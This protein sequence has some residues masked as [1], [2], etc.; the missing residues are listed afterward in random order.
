MSLVHLVAL[1]VMALAPAERLSAP[2][3]TPLQE[4]D[5]VMQCQTWWHD[6]D[7]NGGAA[8]AVVA[9]NGLCIN[10]FI[11]KGRDAVILE[12]LGKTS[13][14]VP[15]VV[16]IRSGGGD[17]DASMNVAEALQRRRP[18]V[19]ADMVCASSCSD[20]IITAGVR[21]IVRADTFLV[22]HGGIT[23]RLLDDAGP[24]IEALAKAD[25]K[26]KYD[27]AMA[28]MRDVIGA[29][30]ARQDSFMVRA[31]VD[32]KIFAWMDEANSKSGE[33]I[34][35]RCPADSH[36]IQYSREALARFGLTFDEYGAPRS[37]AEVDA[38]LHKLG[39]QS[40]ICYWQE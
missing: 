19:I 38:L 40:K 6:M 30:M 25:P 33:A 37:Q 36:I 31:G 20:Y 34:A 29:Q 26:I 27:A 24:Q 28:H 15:L 17:F 2:V 1:M 22:Y 35:S 13:S 23:L 4:A 7:V 5:A 21:R 10:G 18:T 9:G 39:R 32:P 11:D 3:S 16:V 12:S 8:A 14:E